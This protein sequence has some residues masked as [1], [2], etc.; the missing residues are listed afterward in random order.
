MEMGSFH[1][2]SGSSICVS[3]GGL[4][5]VEIDEIMQSMCSSS[6][7]YFYWTSSLIQ[8]DTGGRHWVN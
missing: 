3:V 2:T 5:F 4:F 7:N 1:L 8:E 6:E